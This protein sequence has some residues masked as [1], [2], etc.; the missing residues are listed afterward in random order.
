MTFSGYTLCKS[1]QT[2]G[3]A[4]TKTMVLH[5]PTPKGEDPRTKLTR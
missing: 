2:Q 5:T 3:I 1:K 4:I